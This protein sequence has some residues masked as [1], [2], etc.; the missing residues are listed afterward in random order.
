M[1]ELKFSLCWCDF[2]HSPEYLIGTLLLKCLAT[3]REY[4][5]HMYNALFSCISAKMSQIHKRTPPVHAPFS[6]SL[7]Q[8]VNFECVYVHVSSIFTI[9]WNSFDC[10]G[11]VQLNIDRNIM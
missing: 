1:Q 4:F 11:F 9:L 6:V 10:F 3:T 7:S 5:A 2:V 8:I